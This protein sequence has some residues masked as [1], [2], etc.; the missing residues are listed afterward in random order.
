MAETDKKSFVLYTKN[1]EQISM[2]TDEQAGQLIKGIF[3]YAENNIVPDFD[4][5][6]VKITFSFIKQYLDQDQKKWE[7]IREKRVEAG[8]KGGKLTQ[9]NAS[10][11]NQ[12]GKQNQANQANAFFASDSDKQNQA[13]QAV[14]ES[15]SVSVN[16]NPPI[17]PLGDES[18]LTNDSDASS[19]SFN[20]F[21]K[22]YPKR[23][24]KGNALKVWN[25]LK[26]DDALVREILSALEKQK[27]SPQW[28]KDDGQF[29]PYPATWLND[30][31]WEDDLSDTSGKKEGE[32]SYDLDEY[33]SLVNNFGGKA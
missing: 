10:F 9:A 13:N 12:E 16:N 1:A 24:A 20:E 31:R 23:K 17:S 32:H 5:I 6:A 7:E 18:D 19:K 25:K 2:L 27:K 4:D 22:V 11:A 30:R 26:P 3:L 33:K 21:W 29:I 15:V 28:Q 14:S 8:R